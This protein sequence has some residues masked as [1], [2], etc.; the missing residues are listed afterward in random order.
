MSSL[1]PKTLG[2]SGKAD[3]IVGMTPVGEGQAGIGVVIVCAGA[4]A[5]AVRWGGVVGVDQS[6]ST[7]QESTVQESIVQESI[8]R[9]SID[10]ESTVRVAIGQESTV[11]EAIDPGLTVREAIDPELT[12]RLATGQEVVVRGGGGSKRSFAAFV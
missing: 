10:R 6:W 9:V 12:V 2:S 7:D 1:S 5:G 8:V 4:S 3:S 11:Q